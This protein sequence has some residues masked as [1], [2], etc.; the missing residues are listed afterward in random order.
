MEP[1]L[2]TI[3]ET[4]A[5]LRVFRKTVERQIAAGLGPLVVRT[6]LVTLTSRFMW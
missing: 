5:L 6:R 3:V 2:C 4:A 1:L